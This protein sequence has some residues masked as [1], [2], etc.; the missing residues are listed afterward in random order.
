MSRQVSYRFEAG[1]EADRLFSINPTTGEIRTRERFD[2]EDQVRASPFY[3]LTVI[4]EDGAPSAIRSNGLPNQGEGEGLVVV[5]DA[6]RCDFC[7]EW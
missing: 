3:T 4:A 7:E 1:T 2:R 5:G 6:D